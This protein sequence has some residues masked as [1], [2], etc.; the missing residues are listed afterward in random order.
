VIANINSVA[1]TA[2]LMKIY[3]TARWNVKTKEFVA[4]KATRSFAF[5]KEFGLER[6]ATFHHLVS[7]MIVDAVSLPQLINACKFPNTLSK[8]SKTKSIHY[9]C[10]YGLI[11]SC[12]ISDG[13]SHPDVVVAE[14]HN[15]SHE[16]SVITMLMMTLLL[17][18]ILAI[19]AVIYVRRWQRRT[20]FFAHARLN[21][22]VE[23]IT[24]PIFDFAATEREDIA[25]PVT[26][27]SHNDDKVS[28]SYRFDSSI[29]L[30]RFNI[31][32]GHFS[33]PLYESM[34]AS[35]HKGLL[36]KKSDDDEEEIKSDLL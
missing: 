21:E 9:R 25:M 28:D 32:Q 19:V 10:K 3:Q 15:D 16:F 11:Q 35:S 23:E 29:E 36:E 18:S 14:I 27:I 17:M 12:L 22:N 34:Y 8:S 7:T 2:K 31:V 24:N 6:I 1:I 4:K 5:A 13:L 30:N 33:N 20:R 26:N